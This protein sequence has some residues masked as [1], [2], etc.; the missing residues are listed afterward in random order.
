MRPDRLARRVKIFGLPPRD[1]GRTCENTSNRQRRHVYAKDS[2]TRLYLQDSH[3]FESD[4]RIVAVR[5]NSVAF[6]QTCFY[7]GGGGQPADEGSVRLAA[8]S[9]LKSCLSRRTRTMS[10]GTSATSRPPSDILG[11]PA[12]LILNRERRL[13]LRRYHTVLHVLNTIALRDYG[14][15]ITGV[16]IAADYSRI[17]FKLEGFSA[18]MCAELERKVHAV[19]DGNHRGRITCPKRNSAT[20]TICSG[21]WRPNRRFPR[22][23]CGSWRSGVRCAG[24][25]RHACERHVRSRPVLNLPHRKQGQD[26]QTALCPARSGRS[27]GRRPCLTSPACGPAGSFTR[28]REDAA[29]EAVA[30]KRL[31]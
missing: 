29:G 24:V 2:T 12:T 23:A 28:I 26:E 27:A 9:C 7:P 1:S 16:Q 4:A 25:R 6:D 13:S 31:Q 19:L 22:G 5:E 20:A 11:Q 3:C 10:S 14:G 18:A 8:E 17:D 30:A 21:R 15:W